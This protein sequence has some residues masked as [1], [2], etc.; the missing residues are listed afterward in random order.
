MEG[1]KLFGPYGGTSY[2]LVLTP[3]RSNYT[4]RCQEPIG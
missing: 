4:T 3:V 2:L 1:G